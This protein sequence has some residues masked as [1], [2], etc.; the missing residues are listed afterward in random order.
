MK[1]F[2]SLVSKAMSAET[3]EERM[4]LA[5][6]AVW[7][8]ENHA[9]GY[10]ASPELESIFLEVAKAIPEVTCKP[11]K[12]TVLHVMTQAYGSGGHTRV[13]ERWINMSNIEEKHSVLLLNQETE[14]VPQWLVN[15]A[16]NHGGNFLSL[17]EDDIIKRAYL[18]RQEAS[19]YERVI[20]HV[21]MDDS[22]P[23]IAFGVDSFTI[24]I[25]FF[26]HA[27]HMFWLGVS[28][29]DMVAELRC[30]HISETRRGVQNSYVLGI[31]P[32]PDNNIT[33][34]VDK[35]ALRRELGIPIDD[36]VIITTGSEY[37]YRR[38]GSNSLCKQLVEIVIKGKNVSCYAIGPNIE[39]DQW[40]W[41]NTVSENR[42]HPL[43]VVTDKEKYRKYLLAADLYMG[44]YPYGGYTSM[45]DAVQCGLP[46]LQLLISG[47]QKSMLLMDPSIDQSLCLCHTT[48]EL[49][50]KSMKV[51]RDKRFRETL[52]LTSK[53][54]AD[55]VTSTDDWKCRLYDMY[56][57]CPS[58]HKIR[59]FEIIKGRQVVI[60]D[61]VCL[62]GLMYD[63][64]FEYA[65]RFLRRLSHAWMRI[66]GV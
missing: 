20:L 49:V 33:I 27:D 12:N 64:K 11:Q 32:I 53:R 18:L 25:I 59:Q 16:K 3:I 48:H 43:G 41:A 5:Q 36:F 55:S 45:M 38:I 15:S 46:F 24:P 7:Y 23:I 47:Q 22:V 13:V 37:K 35:K 4:A 30:D 40:G 62:L 17:N 6:D 31:P 14:N 65:N 29:A 60:D 39:S 50:R 21:H 9:T 44:S 56:D 8:A 61:D 63:Y 57:K 52:Y 66:M 26:N 58:K 10:Y 1:T 2:E 19:K 51:M 54:W 34:D 42:I 28:I